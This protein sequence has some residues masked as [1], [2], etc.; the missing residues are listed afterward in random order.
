MIV[1]MKK[2]V[3]KLKDIL[4]KCIDEPLHESEYIEEVCGTVQCENYIEEYKNAYK[5]GRVEQCIDILTKMALYDSNNIKKR[6]L[7]AD[8][9]ISPLSFK[10]TKEEYEKVSMIFLN[11]IEQIKRVDGKNRFVKFLIEMC[12]YTKFFYENGL[13]NT[14]MLM[15]SKFF[16]YSLAEELCMICIFLQ[17]QSRLVEEKINAMIRENRV[18]TGMEADTLFF[19]NSYIQDIQ[20]SASDGYETNLE[21]YD[22]LIKYLFFKKRKELNSDKEIEIVECFPYE[23]S[24]F[25]EISIIAYQ[26]MMYLK[27]E[28]KYRFSNWKITLNKNQDGREIYLFEPNDEE[29]RIVQVVAINRRQLQFSNNAMATTYGIENGLKYVEKIA[30][31]INVQNLDFSIIEKN[32]YIKALEYFR[33]MRY[34]AEKDCKSYYLECNI[35]GMKASDLFDVYEFL[36]ILASI[37]AYA[38][39]EYFDQTDRYSYK[40]LAPIIDLRMLIDVFAEL[41]GVSFNNSEKVIREFVFDENTSK[42]EGDIFTRPL[43]KVS[44]SKVIFCQ[45]L[46]QQVNM[47]RNVEKVLQK[48]GMDLSIV[49]RIYE[50]E[51][52]KRLKDSKYLQVNEN[53]IEFRAYDG[54]NVE[55]DC[56]ATFQ[57]YLLLVECKAVLTPYSDKEILERKKRIYEGVEQVLRRVKV[58]QNDWDK[59]RKMASIPL[60]D[61]PYTED[62][63][64]KL[65]CTDVYD[66]TTLKIDGVTI[67]D[68]STLLKYFKDPIIKKMNINHKEKE[69]SVSIERVL[70]K[71]NMP[72]PKEFIDFI[73]KP[74]TV[75]YFRRCIHSQLLPVVCFENEHC[76]VLKDMYL[77]E[78]PFQEEIDSNKKNKSKIYPNDQCPCGSGKKYKKCCGRDR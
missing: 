20:S 62:K 35:D 40:Y 24:I 47:S 9:L 72:K 77:D 38:C 25:E 73:E 14:K 26:R 55:F 70:W 69:M 59:I 1:D 17:D 11:A 27:A 31:K 68:D 19:E 56:F 43:I 52:V 5:E 54:R 75:E 74:N 53:K 41:Y 51:V 42:E 65:V 6:F 33:P 12:L 50:K 18:V 30:K 46:I 49:G 3:Y 48:Y 7:I 64:I 71:E 28:E 39:T 63:I 32:D 10:Y 16:D 44:R 67:T 21:T 37:Y 34:A 15:N 8:A 66:F 57:D 36:N 22:T 45:T 29:Q 23:S 2:Y 78:N 60:P 61:E 13:A 58:V 4:K 76:L